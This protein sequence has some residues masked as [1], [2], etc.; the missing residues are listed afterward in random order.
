MRPIFYFT[1]M[2]TIIK[3]FVC[4]GSVSRSKPPTEYNFVPFDNNVFCGPYRNFASQINAAAKIACES[5]IQE[6]SCVPKIFCRKKVSLYKGTD[7]NDRNDN[8]A[9]KYRSVEHSVKSQFVR[10]VKVYALAHWYQDYSICMAQRVYFVENDDPHG[11]EQNCKLSPG[12]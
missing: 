10:K 9:N 4:G 6:I 11:R 2:I 3:N 8:D 12:H 5:A 7:K 1:I